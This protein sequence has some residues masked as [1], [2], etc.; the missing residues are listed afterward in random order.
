MSIVGYKYNTKFVAH[1]IAYGLYGSNEEAQ[2]GANDKAQE[3]YPIDDDY[4]FRKHSVVTSPMSYIWMLETLKAIESEAD[5][6]EIYL[7]S[8]VAYKYGTVNIEHCVDYG[9]FDSDDM[10]IQAAKAKANQVYPVKDDSNRY[11][12]HSIVVGKISQDWIREAL[13]T[14]GEIEITPVE[15]VESFKATQD[16]LLS[17]LKIADKA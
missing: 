2:Q 9:L 7:L 1:D 3:M 5:K 14:L 12:S 15:T 4:R 6:R 17:Q 11:Q 13:K 8:I 10:A 16:A